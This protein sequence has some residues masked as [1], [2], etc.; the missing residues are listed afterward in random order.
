MFTAIILAEVFFGLAVIPAIAWVLGLVLRV[1]G[2][3]LKAMLSLL[4]ILLLPVWLVV[5]LV[6]GIAVAA[7]L[8]VPVALLWL[9]FSA[10]VPET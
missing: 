7:R 3:T 10:L 6:G 1:F 8:L 2:W 4:G 5:M 9:L